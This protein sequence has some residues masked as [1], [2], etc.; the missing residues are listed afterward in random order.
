M[1]GRRLDAVCLRQPRQVHALRKHYQGHSR[2][3]RPL[4]QHLDVRKYD[5]VNPQAFGAACSATVQSCTVSPP[6]IM[7]VL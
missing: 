5:T 2:N 4:R 1:V 6:A 7:D 3:R